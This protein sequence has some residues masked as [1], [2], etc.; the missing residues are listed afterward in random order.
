[1]APNLKTVSGLQESRWEA[2]PVLAVNASQRGDAGSEQDWSPWCNS[3]ISGTGAGRSTSA[4]RLLQAG[5]CCELRRGAGALRKL[6]PATSAGAGRFR[7][8]V[9]TPR[10]GSCEGSVQTGGEPRE[11]GKKQGEAWPYAR[12]LG[13][14]SAPRPLGRGTPRSN[15][16]AARLGGEEAWRGAPAPDGFFRRAARCFRR[17][18]GL[19]SEGAAREGAQLW[20]PLLPRGPPEDRRRACA[21]CARPRASPPC[22]GRPAAMRAVRPWR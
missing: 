16:P 7:P 20:N 17:A 5:R 2:S 6:A 4:A 12:P 18:A 9:P 13:P 21:P 22:A 8:S 11:K 15:P 14:A 19:W 10:A 3:R 1:M